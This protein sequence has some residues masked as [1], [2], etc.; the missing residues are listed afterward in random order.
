[1]AERG[2]LRKYEVHVGHDPIDETASS[3]FRMT[4]GEMM[5]LAAS[6]RKAQPVDS[7]ITYDN[8]PMVLHRWAKARCD[9]MIAPNV[10]RLRE[11]TG[12]ER[13]S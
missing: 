7:V 2:S 3:L 9:A 11:R 6:I 10:V 8:L 13:T 5:E 12:S 4:Y 1:M